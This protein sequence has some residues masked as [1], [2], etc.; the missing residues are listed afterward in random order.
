MTSV[1]NSFGAQ[2][3]PI[4]LSQLDANFAVTLVNANNLSDVLSITS[5][6]NNLGLGTASLLNGNVL[7]QLASS[8]TFTMGQR[9]QVTNF[10]GTV[11]APFV[12]DFR[13]SNNWA[14]TL[15]SGLKMGF[16]ATIPAGQ[17]GVFTFTQ[18]S[19]GNCQISVQSGYLSVGSVVSLGVNPNQVTPISYYTPTTG[20]IIL[21]TLSLT[22]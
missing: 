14:A 19:S 11:D 13:I 18:S 9:G 15:T 10:S 7:A 5:A 6:R 17:S 4:P 22:S 21:S 8:E 20:M 1:P 12:P 2:S 16:P 3:G